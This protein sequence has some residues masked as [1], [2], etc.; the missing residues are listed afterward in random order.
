MKVTTLIEN[1][2][3][4]TD[5]RLVAEWGLSL[6][7]EFNEHQILF[8]TGITGAFAQNA[9]Q[10][11]ISL[12]SIGTAVLSHHHY[13]HGGGL[14]R[15]IRANESARIYLGK[16]PTGE[17]FLKILPFVNK[18][19]GLDKTLLVDYPER[20]S[21]VDKPLEVLPNVFIFPHILVK[22]PK[23][24]GNSRIMVRRDGKL[25]PDDFSH[26]IVLSIKEKDHLVIFTGCSH[27]GILN[28]VDTVAAEFKG[29]PIKAIIGG[30]HLV[31]LP[32][33]NSLA[34]SREEVERLG[35]TVLEYP[36]DQTFTG[37]CTGTKAFAVLK[38]VMG[39]RI[40]DLVT[41][42]RFEI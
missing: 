27:N 24:V 41:G 28:M 18:Y 10:L 23:P 31:S 9:E 40:T 6:H 25:F 1:R 42:S 33:F 3:S 17:C 39:D 21:I 16:V 29:V 19:V 13:D 22:Y 5:K 8:D 15:F 37:H 35:K 36:I 34:G 7:I 20:F 4:R 30:F 38:G 14:G 32:P 2:P 26:E 12:S 11:S